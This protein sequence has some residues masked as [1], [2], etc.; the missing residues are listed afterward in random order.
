MCIRDRP[1]DSYLVMG[2]HRSQSMDSRA[3]SVGPI[4]KS[5]V[6]GLSLIHI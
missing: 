5:A 1:E 6:L 2:D 3:S 4:A